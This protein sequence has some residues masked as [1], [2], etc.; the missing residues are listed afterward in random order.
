MQWHEVHCL[1][2]V[3][4]QVKK[5]LILCYVQCPSIEDFNKIWKNQASMNEWDWAESVL[6]QYLIRC[7]TLRRWVPSRNRDQCHTLL[8]KL[9]FY[10]FLKKLIINFKH[11]GIP[12]LHL[13]FC[14]S[15]G[16]SS[17]DCC[18]N[19]IRPLRSYFIFLFK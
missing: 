14:V 12:I 16:R 9:V 15:I 7:V 1:N 2:R 4:A 11:R 17:V 18:F 13:F 3:I 10:L 19:L 8:L 6:R 5:S